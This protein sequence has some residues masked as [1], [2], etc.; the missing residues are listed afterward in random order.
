MFKFDNFCD[1][2]VLFVKGEFAAF[3]WL[4]ALIIISVE[5]VSA[6]VQN[7]RETQTPC[8]AGAINH[9]PGLGVESR[10]ETTHQ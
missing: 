5:M 3:L 7:V 6:G 4:R 10:G 9:T 2:V 1:V 8:K